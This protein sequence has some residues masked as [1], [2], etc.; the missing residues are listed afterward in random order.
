MSIFKVFIPHKLSILQKFNSLNHVT[1]D[2]FNPILQFVVNDV[3]CWFFFNQECSIMS[4]G[5]NHHQVEPNYDIIFNQNCI[6]HFW[7]N[8]T[9]MIFI[10][11]KS[12]NYTKWLGRINFHK[13]H[14]K[15]YAKFYNPPNADYRYGKIESCLHF[16]DKQHLCMYLCRY[17]H[18]LKAI[19]IYLFP[20]SY[21]ILPSAHWLKWMKNRPK[22]THLYLY[23]NG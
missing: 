6:F 17:L 9:F 21:Y 18:F 20:S 23:I 11:N 22:V 13:Y 3:P 15:Q 19:F 16:N 8:F 4:N 14:V 1:V 2:N 5:N 10:L 12:F 7:N